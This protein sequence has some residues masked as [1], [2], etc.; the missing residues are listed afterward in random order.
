MEN[1]LFATAALWLL[2][3]LCV[4]PLAVYLS[5]RSRVRATVAAGQGVAALDAGA[6]ATIDT[7]SYITA[8]VLVLGTAGLLLGLAGFWFVGFSTRAK[9]W[10]GIL[11]FIALSLLGCGLTKGL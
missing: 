6:P 11:A 2:E 3:A 9:S 7:G 4:A 5:R 1:I 10:P 8:S